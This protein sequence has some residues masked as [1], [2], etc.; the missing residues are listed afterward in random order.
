MTGRLEEELTSED[1]IP[2]SGALLS[3]YQSKNSN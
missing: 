2:I 3:K 1:G